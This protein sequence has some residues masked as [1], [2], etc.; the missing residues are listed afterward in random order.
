MVRE[1]N[2]WVAFAGSSTHYVAPF[3]VFFRLTQNT[4]SRPRRA[5]SQS[6]P[7]LFF[8]RITSPL[9]AINRHRVREFTSRK[10][11]H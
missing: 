7:L 8:L 5:V 11:T 6:R 1:K 4:Q 10:T 2:P 9:Q 3:W